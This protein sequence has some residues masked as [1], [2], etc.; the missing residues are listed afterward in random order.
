MG[1]YDYVNCYYPLPNSYF[2]TAF[3][4][5]D[6]D[7]CLRIFTITQDGKL[8]NEENEEI[9][10]TGWVTIYSYFYTAYRKLDSSIDYKNVSHTAAGE[11]ITTHLKYEIYFKNGKVDG[12]TERRFLE[13][14]ETRKS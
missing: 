11:T 2:T 6:F 9:K 12:V 1:L 13:P 7:N 10:Y 8:L 4:T 5:Q 3:Q 14:D